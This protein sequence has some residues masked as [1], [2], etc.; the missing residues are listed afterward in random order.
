MKVIAE[1]KVTTTKG[2][3][4]LTDTV[5][6]ATKIAFDKLHLDFKRITKDWDKKRFSFDLEAEMATAP[7][8][9]ARDDS[10]SLSEQVN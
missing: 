8:H 6:Q 4:A 10:S 9:I 1:L 3:W 7:I 5:K 2:K